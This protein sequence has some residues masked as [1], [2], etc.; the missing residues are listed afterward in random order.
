[1]VAALTA[2]VGM[3]GWS[4]EWEPPPTSRDP[5]LSADGT[6]VAFVTG[7]KE[8]LLGQMY[9]GGDVLVKTLATGAITRV[10][11]DARGREGNYGSSGPVLSADGTRVA[12]LSHA[13]NLVPGDMNYHADVFVKDLRTGEVSR[14]STTASGAEVRKPGLNGDNAQEARDRSPACREKKHFQRAG[15]QLALSGDGTTVAF[16]STATDLVPGDDNDCR[17]VFVKNLRTGAIAR[18]SAP[19]GASDR[20]VALSADGSTVAYA[21]PLGDGAALVVKNLRTGR[22]WRVAAK[23]GAMSKPSLSAD[24]TKVAFV[25]AAHSLVRGDDNGVQD[26]FVK[27]LATGVV[28]RVST[29]ARV[30]PRNHGADNPA[31]SPDGTSVAFNTVWQAVEG[32]Y[33]YASDVYVKDLRTGRFRNA[34]TS[35]TGAALDLGVGE[36]RISGDGTSVAFVIGENVYVKNLVTGGLVRSTPPYD[37]RPF[38]VR[39]WSQLF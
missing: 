35:P 39:V 19:T 29:V 2:V 33:Q 11:T 15:Q 34:S 14:A 9:Y 5:A 23:D 36:P 3:A 37:D 13:T 38:P 6:T 24:G 32:G 18:A 17:D 31:I 28:R 26:V 27:D 7:M 10:S 4:Y 8:G 12:F 20:G 25:S 1:M 21:S 22:I 30:G 16:L